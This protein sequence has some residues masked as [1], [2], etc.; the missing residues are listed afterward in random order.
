MGWACHEKRR[1]PPLLGWLGWT[2][3]TLNKELASG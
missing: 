2:L 3:A 1:P